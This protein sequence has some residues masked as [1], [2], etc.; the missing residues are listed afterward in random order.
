LLQTITAVSTPYQLPADPFWREEQHE[1]GP[2]TQ[3]ERDA[4]LAPSIDIAGA[5]GAAMPPPGLLAS[6]DARPGP[7]QA[8]SPAARP[9]PPSVRTALSSDVA[10]VTEATAGAGGTPAPPEGG[11]NEAQAGEFGDPPASKAGP[12]EELTE[13]EQKEVDEL[14]GRDRE[15]RQHEQAHM[16]AAGAYARGGPRYEYTTGPDNKR[17]ATGGEVSIDTSS[18]PNDPEATIRKAQTVYRAAMAPAEP[19]GQDRQVASEA[20]KMEMEARQELAEK[21]REEMGGPLGG[22]KEEGETGTETTGA[23]GPEPGV[24]ASAADDAAP[25]ST[26]SASGATPTSVTVID[27][28]GPAPTVEGLLDLFA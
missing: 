19:S 25:E 18:I 14:Q 27:E 9:Q 23:S 3:E 4:V 11:T 20:K 2:T 22:E 5:V 21:R 10:P 8:T 28:A 13:E 17:Y 24:G 16:A 1:S 12:G 7:E 6:L 26:E 15:V